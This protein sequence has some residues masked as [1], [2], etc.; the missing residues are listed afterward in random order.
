MIYQRSG[1]SLRFL[2]VECFRGGRGAT[3][4]LTDGLVEGVEAMYRE[5]DA[6][7]V[8]EKIRQ[9]FIKRYSQVKRALRGND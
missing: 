3:V 1:S 4:R 7:S 5:H 8:E 2:K 9:S 6:E